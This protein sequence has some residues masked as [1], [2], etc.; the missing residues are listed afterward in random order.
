MVYNHVGIL[1]QEGSCVSLTYQ[2][3]IQ[4]YELEDI[5][6]IECAA[7]APDAI[8]DWGSLFPEDFFE[9]YSDPEDEDPIQQRFAIKLD[10]HHDGDAFRIGLRGGFEG[11][12]GE[13]VAFAVA[14]YSSETL[15]ISEENNEAVLKFANE[16]GVL[17]L[18]P[19]LRHAIADLTTRISGDPLLLPTLRFGQLV[20]GE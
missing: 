14:S 19:Y 13:V 6:L 20:F 11:P 3:L 12:F 16:V 18:F 17:S 7:R 1:A 2:D 15:Q 9:G 5:R 8:A 4:H 10:I